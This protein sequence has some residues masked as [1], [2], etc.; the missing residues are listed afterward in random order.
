MR[1]I[2]ISILCFSFIGL[3]AQRGNSDFGDRVVSNNDQPGASGDSLVVVR[4][5]TLSNEVYSFSLERLSSQVFFNDSLLTDFEEYEMTNQQEV[6]HITLGNPGSS[7]MPLFWNKSYYQ[8]FRLGVDQYQPYQFK[9]QDIRFYSLEKP[10]SKVYFSPGSTQASF[11]SSAILARDFARNTKVS[12]HF[13]RINSADIYEQSQNRHTFFHAGVYQRIDSTKFAYSVNLISNSNFEEFNGGIVDEQSLYEQGGQIRSSI[14]VR[15]GEAYQYNLNRGLTTSAYYFL[16]DRDSTQQYLQL[17]MEAGRELYKFINPSLTSND[18]LIFSEDL[19]TSPLGMRRLVNN[20]SYSAGLSYHLE[21]KRFTSRY[22]LKYSQNLVRT[23]LSNSS[24]STI[25]GGGENRFEWKGLTVNLDGY[26][27]ASYGVFLLDLHPKIGYRYRAFA[28]VEA[29]FRLHTEPSPFL[30]NQIEVTEVSLLDSDAFTISSQ[31]LYGV[32]KIPII[33]FYGRVSS[34]AGQNVPIL[35][36]D[37]KSIDRVNVNY[38]QID[39]EEKFKYK[40]FRFNNR[41][42]SQVR[43]RSVYGMPSFYTEHELF[44][45]GK[46]FG[47]LNFHAGINGSFIPSYGLPAFNPFYARY[48]ETEDQLS[49]GPFYRIDP[50]ASIK[51]QGFRFFVKYEFLNGLWQDQ[52]IFQAVNNPQLD[53]RLRLGISWELRN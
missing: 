22:Y 18:T 36:D 14:S 31:E 15:L 51:V 49:K 26:T 41:F 28:D 45:D 10:Y 4:K 1:Y 25:V 34:F 20:N 39:L 42:I 19:I 43:N 9:S 30:L 21:N 53:P 37:G 29:G 32:V 50:F 38:L 2:L 40:W 13:N 16:Q 47:S 12:V 44:F 6:P 23:D 7:T 17:K 46:L 27:G 35:S 8:G 24:V 52:V 33:G 11:R 5:D 3:T 48:Y